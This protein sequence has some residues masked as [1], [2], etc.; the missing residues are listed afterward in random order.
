MGFMSAIQPW[1]DD[2]LA[3]EITAPV[4]EAK[5]LDS[6]VPFLTRNQ[7]YQWVS[8][9]E[10]S[11]YYNRQKKN[12]YSS[13]IGLI[14]LLLNVPTVMPAMLQIMQILDDYIWYTA[15]DNVVCEN[16]DPGFKLEISN[17]NC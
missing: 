9:P 1:K 8:Y 7:N 3:L 15:S 17:A 10:R 16:C 5:L 11:I 14:T 4:L 2:L 12:S 6:I 13:T